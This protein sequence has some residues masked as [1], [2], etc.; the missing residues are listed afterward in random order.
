MGG[1]FVI[2]VADSVGVGALPDAAAY[3]DA[4]SDTL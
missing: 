2:L 4:G 3:G 1:R